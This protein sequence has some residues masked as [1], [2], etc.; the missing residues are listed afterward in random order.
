VAVRVS[1]APGRGL[2]AEVTNTAPPAPPVAAKPGHGL[3]GL[4]ERA[5]LTGGRL[6]HGP[7]TEGGWRLAAWLPWPP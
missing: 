7:T 6:D 2:A 1:G 3:L 5:A 4:A